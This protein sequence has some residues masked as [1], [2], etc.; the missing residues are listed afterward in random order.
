M[1][2]GR[3]ARH[4]LL[5]VAVVISV[6][7]AADPTF[8]AMWAVLT[9]SPERP[10]AGERAEVLI[11]TFAT[12]GPDAVGSLGHD[13]PI[14]APSDSVLVIWGVDYPFQL[15]A[16]GPDGHH[17]DVEVHQDPADASLYRGA[18]TFPSAGDWTLRL[19]QFPGP[20]DAPGIRL[21]VTVAERAPP[22]GEAAPP[23]GDMAQLAAAA[24]LGAIA[25]LGVALALRRRA[26]SG[27]VGAR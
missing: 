17:I 24:G 15:V 27:D 22:V 8:A 12:Y 26:S 25:G 21:A 18:V 4:S 6:L 7:A 2:R 1:S 16:L 5:A 11:R 14:P 9:L 23:I 3:V 20:E 19:P 10:A 13:G